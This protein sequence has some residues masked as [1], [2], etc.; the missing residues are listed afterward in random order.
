MPWTTR[1]AEIQASSVLS[2]VSPLNEIRRLFIKLSYTIGNDVSSLQDNEDQYKVALEVREQRYLEIGF[3]VIQN[4]MDILGERE[5]RL[6]SALD[7]IHRTF[8]DISERAK[9]LLE[10]GQNSVNL[11]EESVPQWPSM[12]LE[13]IRDY[14]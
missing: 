3:D 5:V 10:T 6:K 9:R 11:V 4:E 12:Y 7:S 1:F 2:V 8:S 13:G 14:F